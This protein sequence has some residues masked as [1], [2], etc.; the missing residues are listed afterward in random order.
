M[1]DILI[2]FDLQAFSLNTTFLIIHFK[3][4]SEK[5]YNYFIIKKI[6]NEGDDGQLLLFP[7]KVEAKSS[8]KILR[9]ININKISVN[10]TCL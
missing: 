10:Q 9:G 6:M 1:E 2:I 7:Q 3:Q 5:N 8:L 4:L